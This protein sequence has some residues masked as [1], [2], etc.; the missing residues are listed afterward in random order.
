MGE[1]NSRPKQHLAAPCLWTKMKDIRHFASG[2]D[3][4]EAPDLVSWR[5]FWLEPTGTRELCGGVRVV[6]AIGRDQQ[7]HFRVVVPIAKRET[8]RET[9][10]KKR[11]GREETKIEAEARRR[12]DARD[13]PFPFWA[14]SFVRTRGTWYYSK[15]MVHSIRLKTGSRKV[16]PP[17]PTF[18]N[19][20]QLA[21][22]LKDLRSN[23]P[24]RPHGS[25]PLPTKEP[26]ASAAPLNRELPPRASSALSMS[27]PGDSTRATASDLFPRSSSALSHR[28]N[29]SE[30]SPQNG[31][32]PG[33]PEDSVHEHPRNLSAATSPS[34]QYRENGR[35]WIERQDARSLRNA[36]EEMDLQD[37]EQQLYAAAQAEAVDLVLQ[38]QMH[39][40]PEQNPHAPYNNPDYPNQF[41]RHPE[42]WGQFGGHDSTLSQ[43][44]R[45][46]SVSDSSTGSA[47][48]RSSL[49][50]GNAPTRTGVPQ[51][52]TTLKVKK[53]SSV[54]RTS[55]VNFA[56]PEDDRQH[57]PQQQ[58]SS[59]MSSGDSSKGLFRNPR[60]R[61]YEE[62]EDSD[63]KD[64]IKTSAFAPITSALRLKSRNSIPHG[65]RPLPGQHTTGSNIKKPSIF[66]VYRNASTQSKNPLYKTNAFPTAAKASGGSDTT[67]TKNGIEIRSDDIRAATSMRFKDRSSK[68]PMPSA[69]SDRPGRPIVSFDPDWKAPDKET[70]A[71]SGRDSRGSFGRSSPRPSTEVTPASSKNSVPAISV[72]EAA[73]IPT[74]NIA[75]EE[76]TKPSV[77]ISELGPPVSAL[78]PQQDQ[79]PRELPDPKKYA[80]DQ[81]AKKT[82]AFSRNRN[83]H[84][85]P[86]N[87]NA[88]AAACA[89]C[90]LPISGR[91]VTACNHRLHPE[92]FTCYHCSTP[93][94]CVAFYQE[95]DSSTRVRTSC[96]IARRPRSPKMASCKT[97]I[98]GE[99]IIA[100]GAEWHVGHFFCAEC[101]DPFT[102]K[103]PFIEKEGYAW[104]VRCHSRRTAGSC[105][106][107]KR[108]VLEDVVVTALG[109][110]W[111][112]KC[113]VC[114]ECGDGFGPEGRFF[115][116]Q[117][118]PRVTAR[119]RQIGGPVELAACEKC[120]ARRLKA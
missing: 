11:R 69:V 117:G 115:L 31:E 56:L 60:D 75:C 44:E 37:D 6:E 29:V 86:T 101:G 80:Q 9:S 71:D 84:I 112:E 27:R 51:D 74:I 41:R 50:P 92:C 88:P 55:K 104:C 103:T 102:P 107:C 20:D 2:S 91:I 10:L 36:L 64:E 83:S 82:L 26:T 65:A 59:R 18:M 35:R 30:I 97:P 118:K 110:Q 99:V 15:S 49:P 81:R 108:P 7:R 21:Y 13:P 111:H 85:T 109:G 4:C 33:I 87:I 19:D 40:F 23:R 16:S 28:R 79:K 43:P 3:K 47:P 25:R 46:R 8:K 32:C 90:G 63:S 94:E 113:F 54:K 14:V 12:S 114:C 77:T 120:E 48:N 95:P 38:H 53:N 61:I 68:L 22:Y 89:A 5:R 100:C 42:K 78:T 39:G 119:G 58:T 34:G 1:L 62:L 116:R 45:D 17:N 52:S 67:P 72:N 73:D 98:E 93:L 66:D 24:P 57:N 70:P 96:R 105:R 76:S 106:G